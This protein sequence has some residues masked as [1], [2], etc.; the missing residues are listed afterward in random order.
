MAMTKSVSS[1]RIAKR[2]VRSVDLVRDLPDPYALQGYVVTPSVR[3]AAAR[4]LSGLRKSST[5]RAFRVTGPYGVGKSAFALLL[6]RLAGDR[7]QRAGAPLRLLQDAGVTVPED[8]PDYLPLVLV[9]RR[10][11]LADCIV[12]A[13]L[14]SAERRGAKPAP[15][16]A[17]RAADLARE[18]GKGRHDDG[19]VLDLLVDYGRES[20]MGILVL[21]DEMGRF[22]EYAALHRREIDPS[23][24]Q[25]L[26]ERAGGAQERALAVVGILHHRFSD[27][28]AGL[29][30]WVEAEWT[31]SAERYE[32]ILFHDSTEQ[33]AFLLAHA[34]VHEPPLSHAVADN[35]RRSYKE[36]VA[37]GV[38][39]T[40]VAEMT[41]ASLSLFPLH[42]AA[43]AALSNV[44][45]RFGQNERS[46]F[47]FL[48]SLEPFGFQRFI[49]ATGRRESDWY[50]IADLFDY[51]SAQGG[52]R[53]RSADR[54]RRWELAVN[55][56]TQAAARDAEQLTVLKT[57]G[58][59]SVLEPVQGLRADA[60]TVAWCCGIAK[61]AVASALRRLTEQNLLYRRPHRE[62]Y[63]LWASTSV[64]LDGWLQKA[65]V[66][67][68]QVKRLDA[69]LGSLPSRSALVA[70]RHYHQTGT[71]RAFAVVS[72]TGQ[73]RFVE[74]RQPDSD[75]MIVVVP[76]Y[77]D[78]DIG[79]V[80]RRI[81]SSVAAR[82]AVNLCCLRKVGAQELAM[83]HELAVWR[84]IESHCPELRMDDLARRE[85]ALRVASTEE[86]LENALRPFAGAGGGDEEIWIHRGK[87]VR[88]GS[89]RDLNR[90]LSEI[91]DEV[92]GSGPV[93]RNE[94]VNRA[95]LSSAAAQARMKL[96]EAMVQ[97]ESLPYLGLS[98]APP[99][100]T[101]YLSMF[102]A[103]GM[104]RNAG[105]DAWEFKPPAGDPRNWLPTW[106]AI[107]RHLKDRGTTT[108]EELIG[109]LAKPPIGL[110]AGPA[111]LVIAAF[112]LHH[113]SEVA[114][115]ERNTFQ[116]DV[117]SA[118]FM[119]LAKTP[120]NFALR[121]LGSSRA[122]LG[123]LE[124]L[125][126]ELVI[127][128]DGPKPEPVIKSV[129]EG[130]YRWWNLQPAFARET[131]GISATAQAVRLTLKKAHEPVDL[132]FRQ[133]PEACGL[134]PVELGR[135]KGGQQDELIELLNQSFQEISDAPLHLRSKAQTG[136]LEAFDAPSIKKLRVL[137]S[138][139]YG[140][141]HLKL[142]DY[143]LRAFVDR[144]SDARTSDDSWLD[145]VASLL[146]GKRLDAWQDDTADTF[147]FEVKAIAGRLMRWLVHMREQVGTGAKLLSV[148]I[149]DTAGHERMTVVRPGV[150]N[151][152]SA[153]LVAEIKTLLSRS[154][155]PASVL[156][157]VM[158]DRLASDD[159]TDKPKEK[160]DG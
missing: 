119:R 13:V 25:Q 90:R 30:E 76:V 123:L 94:L 40:G 149:V 148:H 75:G 33:T 37:R 89:R 134:P 88:I 5:Q 58:M 105:K 102:H 120:A 84:W 47:G 93:L 133:L 137:I 141:H 87:S 24:F 99:E 95:R 7:S 50:R 65:R 2:Y 101:I 14:R 159:S 49:H 57:V 153:A 16:V 1:I 136:L 26:A 4:I 112:M 128:S 82:D 118:H 66:A 52:A 122:A 151:A 155:D 129:V 110:R 106:I 3:D 140:P 15:S 158:A 78:E 100:R 43:V 6:A 115:L 139:E 98:G 9:G 71:L 103:S 19:A 114:L 8:L 142:T 29:G 18:R 39:T 130:I 41:D 143:R 152:S 121:Y 22:L 85:V 54:E 74:E 36:A 83:A 77:P 138:A 108:F 23:F 11:N 34:V 146:T 150:L 156:A 113:R 86:A 144:S 160:A 116:P 53:F 17:K 124:R 46:V 157:H 56:V 111:L 104:H 35:A 117:T 154:N 61:G 70:H 20:K 38:F 60:D 67:V 147:T 132:V 63:S 96:L 72:W 135:R 73:G 32:D 59:I 125:S 79:A 44:A 28:A 42:P 131:S 107:E 69:A 68:V 92:F 145:G 97:S 64:D 80:K 48:Q 31:R 55:A 81:A 127:W 51:V 62:D 109:E 12:E 91:C 27:Y 21:V 126:S 45:G 10:A